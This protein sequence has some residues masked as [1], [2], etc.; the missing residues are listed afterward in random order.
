[1]EQYRNWAPAVGD[2]KGFL[3]PDQQDWY[4]GPSR[5][6]GSDPLGE[7]NFITALE[8]LG[9]ES[10]HVQVHH[11]GHWFEGW[12]EFILVDNTHEKSVETLRQME[13]D[14][15]E[16]PVLDEHHHSELEY[17]EM[18]TAWAAITQEER[19]DLCKKHALVNAY[20]PYLSDEDNLT[21]MAKNIEEIPDGIYAE[22]LIY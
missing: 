17:A 8:R 19:E 14:M 7:S 10:V 4:V 11:F 9:G 21:Q 5:G 1:M 12:I 15:E 18:L 20:H 2:K 22:H 16:Y 6:R 13:K 3:I